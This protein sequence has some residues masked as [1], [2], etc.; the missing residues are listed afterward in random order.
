MSINVIPYT[1]GLAE[2]WDEFVINRSRNGGMF[3]ERKFLDYHP[4]GRF[5]DVSLV[6]RND[7][8]IIGVFPAV[9]VDRPDSA[10]AVV[11]HPGSTAG[12]LVYAVDATAR[13]V[14]EQV[15]AALL[16]YQCGSFG[17]I[18]LRLAEALFSYPTDGELTY[19]LWHRGFR[20]AT[21]EISS[22]VYLVPEEGWLKFVNERKRRYMR[23]AAASKGLVVEQT[24][25][26]E[27]VYRLIETNLGNRFYKKP[28]HSLA[29]LSAL[30]E[31]YPDRLHL[32]ITRKDDLIV[33]TAV[34]FAVNRQAVHDFY[35][36]N[37]YT[38]ANLHAQPVLYNTMF[39]HY[40]ERGYR[41]FSIGISSRGDWI[42]WGILEFKEKVG[43]RATFR[44]VWILD[45]LA[46]YKAYLFDEAQHG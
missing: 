19:L 9:R 24:N 41:W 43:A 36:H 11:S 46:D 8:E 28:T 37:D 6:F 15:E 23:N 20:L 3:Q 29:E 35:T 14:L 26:V 4:E 40:Q 32:W 2:D 13:E 31:L 38:Y 21:R 45:N 33:A 10:P 34:I 25:N 22:C 42:K 7:R 18:E 39:K 30:K 12:G 1:P 27:Q 5:N 16:Y 17:S 44:D